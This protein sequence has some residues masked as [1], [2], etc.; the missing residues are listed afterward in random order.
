MNLP[1]PP[2]N[3]PCG[4]C[5]KQDTVFLIYECKE[6]MPDGLP[7]QVFTPAR[8]MELRA[9]IQYSL[10]FCQHCGMT[11]FVEYES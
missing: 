6:T 3:V 9:N 4:N 7:L 10:H 8:A 11:T 1:N 2:Q 5:R